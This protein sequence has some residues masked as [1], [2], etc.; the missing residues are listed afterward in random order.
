MGWCTTFDLDQFAAA[1]GGYLRSRAAENTLLL[2]A[3]QAARDAKDAKDG[4]AA[5]AGWRTQVAGQRAEAAGPVVLKIYRNCGV[6]QAGNKVSILRFP[7]MDI[8]F[9]VY[10]WRLNVLIFLGCQQ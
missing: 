9:S 10:N 8:C 4:Q 7:G 1:A 5:R 3:A 6:E 2:S